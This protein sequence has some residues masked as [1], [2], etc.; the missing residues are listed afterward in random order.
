MLDA[1]RALGVDLDS[2]CGGRGICGRC[3]IRP[4]EGAFPKHGI[5]SANDH[6]SPFTEPE[7]QYRERD[8]WR[9]TAGSVVTRGSSATW[10]ST[11]RRRARCTDRSCARRLT[12]TRSRSTRRAA[13]LRRGARS[14]R[15]KSPTQR[16]QRLLEALEREWGA[17]GLECR[18]ARARP[19]SSGRSRAGALDRSRSRCTT[20]PDH[21]GVARLPRRRARDRV[22]RRID[23]GR[24]ASVRS[25]HAARCSRRAGAMNP[26]IRFGED[27]MS[28][29]S[30][31]MMHPVGRRSSRAAVRGVPG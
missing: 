23:D 4:M 2:V 16:S 19:R 21:G 30:Y 25:A 8:G 24:R 15:W 31:V 22:R 5:T 12:R 1:A 27:L 18:P 9:T 7:A 20:G 3:Q 11:C 13:L 14:R 29:V 26:Q 28:R 17:H 10:S 6:L